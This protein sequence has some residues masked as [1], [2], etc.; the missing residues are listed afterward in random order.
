M[1]FHI[2]RPARLAMLLGVA[3]ALA[4]GGCTTTTG[5]STGAT[6]PGKP[7]SGAGAATSAAQ[8]NYQPVTDIPIPPGTKINTERSTILGG[9]DQWYGKMLLV[10][11][12]SSTMAYSYYTEQMP[13]F[14]WEL[15]T[16]VQGKVAT[17][18]YVQGQRA[19]TIEIEPAAMRGS[20][21]MVTM[22]PRPASGP[23]RTAS[24]PPPS[25]QPK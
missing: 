23:G 21:V 4:L 16:A 9:P 8:N 7:G 14:G 20:E 18:T 3:G 6:R 1:S 10:L 12:R 17:L 25:P 5:T 13:A 11:D 24:P 22:S 2:V 19:A 15:I